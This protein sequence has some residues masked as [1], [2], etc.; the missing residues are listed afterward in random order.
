MRN[1]C[2]LILEVPFYVL[3]CFVYSYLCCVELASCPFYCGIRVTPKANFHFM[4]LLQIIMFFRI[5]IPAFSATVNRNCGY[6][7]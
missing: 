4:H 5:C 1:I 7:L 6:E 3:P 2:T